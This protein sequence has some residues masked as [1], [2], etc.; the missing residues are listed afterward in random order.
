MLNP[1]RRSQFISPFGPGAIQILHNGF[2]ALTAGLDHWMEKPNDSI[3][4]FDERV[5]EYKISEWRLQAALE[6]DFFL[7]PPD[8][9]APRVGQSVRHAGL[10]VPVLRFPTWHVCSGTACGRMDKAN[11]WRT[12]R[13]K[14]PD[15]QRTMRQVRFIAVCSKGHLQDFP[16]C[17][18]VH[19]SISPACS[20]KLK[21]SSTGGG[22]LS[23][24]RVT[25]SACSQ[26]R[27]LAGVFSADS[28]GSRLSNTLDESDSVYCCPGQRPW[29]GTENGEGCEGHLRGALINATNV[30]YPEMRSAVFV[31]PVLAASTR[32]QAYDRLNAPEIKPLVKMLHG[33]DAEMAAD[34]LL[35]K[36]AGRL[37]GFDKDEIVR[38]IHDVWENAPIT[39]TQA[40]ALPS[41]DEEFRELE[42]RVL[43]Q[44]VEE[45]ELVTRVV[46]LATISEELRPYF[47]KIVRVE[48][49]RET[50]VLTGFSRIDPESDLT[51]RQK[52]KLLWRLPPEHGSRWLPAYTVRGEGIFLA[53]SESV[54]QEWESGPSVEARVRKLDVSYGN[55]AQRRGYRPRTISPRFVLIHTFTHLLIN[56]LVFECGYST[57]SLRERLYVSR[58]PGQEMAGLLIYTASGDS[59]GTL[60]GLVRM[61]DRGVLDTLVRTSLAE[62]A[63]CSSDPI[64]EEMSELG[65]QGPDSCNLAACHNCSLMPETSC[66]EFNRFLDRGLVVDIGRAGSP[67]FFPTLQR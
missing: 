65:G 37:D 58:E 9:R 41:S 35:A 56:H 60:G 49:L 47:S 51:A 46:D 67:A 38:A 14:C 23:A 8:Y 28:R 5:E 20:G 32:S 30:Y 54:L 45:D 29:L 64:C 42:F 31:P 11:L 44:E 62:A 48:R 53:F 12:G 15:C 13:I 26:S 22:S 40:S 3:G 50:R 18:W 4:E 33:G 21:Y 59:D 57:A 27:S 39:G 61:A 66:E 52:Q 19:R 55:A 7:T 24:I 6:V 16:W 34:L 25:C 10:T 1:V 36:H 63:W 17:Q 2:A 43:G